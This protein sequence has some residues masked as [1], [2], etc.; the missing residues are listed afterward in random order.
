M[1]P[2]IYF[3][4]GAFIQN[5]DLLSVALAVAGTFVLGFSVYFSNRQSITNKTFLAFS[6][7]TA[8]W[9]TINYLAYQTVNPELVL[10]LFRFIMFF[11]VWQAFTFFQL[12]FVFPNTKQHFSAVYKR[13]LVPVVVA[14]SLITLSPLILSGII[15]LTE[16]GAVSEAEVGPGIFFFGFIAVGLV[17]SGLVVLVNKM[18]FIKVK[19]EKQPQ[20]FM[21]YGALIMFALIVVFNFLAPVVTS[22]R[23]FIP[24]GALFVFPF[25]AFTSYAVLKHKLFNIKV[26]GA[27]L[28]VF[29]L[30]VIMFLEVIFAEEFFL[31]LYRSSILLLVLLFGILLIRNVIREVE[32]REQLEILSKELAAANAELKKLDQ[33]K[34]D[35]LSFVSHQLRAPLTVIK[36]YI[37]MIEEGT[38][39]QIPQNILEVLGKVFVSNEKL[40]RLVNDFLNL[41]R[42]EQGRLQFEFE[43]TSVAA[44][45][46][47]AVG[48][49]KDNAAKRG[50]TLVWQKPEAVPDITIDKSKVYEI[51]YNLIDNAIKY[52]ENGSVSVELFKKPKSVVIAVKD[53]GIGLSSD[54]QKQLFQRFGRV[55]AGKKVNITG[56]GI[57]LYVAKYMVEAQ[58]G[59]IWAESAGRGKGST[60]FVEL[61]LG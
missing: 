61:P 38:Y 57:G 46:E 23:D 27:S 7:V 1:Q 21:L 60:F 50:L 14:T 18:R 24:L 52:T 19:T 4:K 11:A 58:K 17:L 10:W 44:L 40:I 35:F 42:I 49:L 47:E 53:T 48:M 51:I 31:V 45:I 36:G 16:V 3:T 30:S 12:F 39:G 54:D 34:S 43:K 8:I 26:A 32:Q 29:V 56:T 15:E 20:E 13:V 6:I 37:S 55:E 28:L 2:L 22:N 25:I 33:L 59:R 41:S 5:L 9:G